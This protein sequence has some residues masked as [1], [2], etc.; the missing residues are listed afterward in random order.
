[1]SLANLSTLKDIY[2][3]RGNSAA[4][5]AFFTE[6]IATLSAMDDA[7]DAVKDDLQAKI[8]ALE[9]KIDALEE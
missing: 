6:L 8:D 2:A 4:G 3:E 5:T 1:M 9:A 7:S